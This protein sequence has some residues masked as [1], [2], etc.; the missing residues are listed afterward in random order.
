MGLPEIIIDENNSNLTKPPTLEEV[1]DALFSIDSIKTPGPDGFGAGF[2]KNYWHV[3]KKDLFNCVIEFFTNGKILKEINHTFVALI[4]KKTNP[5]QTSHYRPISLCSTIYKIISKILV[6]RLRPLLNKLISPFQSAFIPGRSIHDNILL[7]HE[8]MHKFKNLRTQTAWAAIKSDM[9]KTYDRIEWDFILKCLQE[10]GF[11][12]TWNS[13]I[14]ECISSVSYSL[15]VNN[16]PNGF[17][18]PTRGIRQGDPLSPYIFILC[19]EALNRMLYIEA[20]TRKSGIGIKL[21]PRDN[22]IPCL[23][24]ADDC[25]LFCK[26]NSDCCKKLKSVLDKFCSLSGQLINFHKSVVT[27]HEMLPLLINS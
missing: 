18:T 24:F 12:P 10:M 14:K 20:S 17:F 2:F 27:L 25:L 19:M 21:S 26:T 23:L 11:H 3:I 5:S 1:K 8:I 4:P 9:E 22:K 7:T 13:W 15:I 16:E 6:N